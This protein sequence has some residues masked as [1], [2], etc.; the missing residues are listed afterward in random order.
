MFKQNRTKQMTESCG[1]CLFSQRH[2]AINPPH[3]EEEVRDDFTKEVVFGPSRITMNAASRRR[4]GSRAST[5]PRQDEQTERGRAHHSPYTPSR[6]A[7]CHSLYKSL[8]PA[9]HY[10]LHVRTLSYSSLCPQHS[11]QHIAS[12]YIDSKSVR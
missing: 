9:L 6:T 11:K 5:Q 3:A 4:G 8:P 1:K 7:Q 2:R 10:Q 12:L